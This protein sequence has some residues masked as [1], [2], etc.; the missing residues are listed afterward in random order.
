MS[1]AAQFRV[2]ARDVWKAFGDNEVLKGVSFTVAQGSVTTIIGPSGSGKTTLLRALNALDRPDR[3]RI[4]V[5]DVELDFADRIAA[6]RLRRY[7]AQSGMVFQSHNLFPHKTVL[8]NVTEG[9]L[10]VQKRPRAEV[11]D[12]AA[13]LLRQVGLAD[14]RDQYPYQL[15]GG[16]QQRVG[17]ARALALRPK[18]VLF[19]EPTSALDP[20][21]VGE[22]L[23]VI[24]DLAVQGWT[25]VVVTH[26]IQFARQV[27]DQVLFT[28]RGVILEQGS[29]A[30][31]IGNP[32]EE[33]TRQ[34]LERILNPL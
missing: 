34:F 1:T 27:S 10:I 3:G 9:P 14:K 31:V 20:E 23:S 5:G 6:D 21:L 7:R 28:D 25:L 2:D 8:E 11:E 13:E 4:K 24:K 32:K 18:V 33:R 15:S 12:E 29:P 30:E 16:Q 26:E 19:D 22:V 17:I